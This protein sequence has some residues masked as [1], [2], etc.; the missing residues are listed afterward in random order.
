M[1]EGDGEERRERER[2]VKRALQP[3]G[4]CQG[5]VIPLRNYKW[6][7]WSMKLKNQRDEAGRKYRLDNEGLCGPRKEPLK[8]F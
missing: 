3:E 6:L 5:R 7:G 4:T 2:R 1:S 8:D